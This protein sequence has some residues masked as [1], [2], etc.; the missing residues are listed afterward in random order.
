[1]GECC[2]NHPK[3]QKSLSGGG[4]SKLSPLS[5]RARDRVLGRIL[6]ISAGPVTLT[7]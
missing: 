6:H 3:S 5:C 1:V 2:G 4:G 7:S